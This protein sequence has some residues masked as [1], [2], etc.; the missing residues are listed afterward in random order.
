VSRRVA[1]AVEDTVPL[2]DIGSLS[3]KGIS[4]PVQVYNV[5]E[6]PLGAS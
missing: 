2:E 4:Q 6:A 1:T 5:R 3:M